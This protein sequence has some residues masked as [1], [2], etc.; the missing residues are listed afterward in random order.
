MFLL[1]LTL[2]LEGEQAVRSVMPE[3]IIVRPA[4]MW[5]P[6][7]EVLRHH[8]Q[9]MKYWPVYP[10]VFPEKLIQPIYVRFPLKTVFFSLCCRLLSHF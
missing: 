6:G 10:L 3:A 5:G 1:A 4:A 2:Q 7:D 8:A 9:L